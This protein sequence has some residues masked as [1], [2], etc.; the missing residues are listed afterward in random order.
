MNSGVSHTLV[1]MATIATA[2]CSL[3]G[4]R[5][6]EETVLMFE[7]VSVHC[8]VR[9]GADR[10]T[11]HLSYNKHRTLRLVKLKRRLCRINK[12][13]M[14]GPRSRVRIIWRTVVFLPVI[15]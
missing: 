7:R 14:L 3:R 4:T 2:L 9:A 10:I 15:T 1:V 5:F 6:G 8:E 11:E 13:A 12:Q